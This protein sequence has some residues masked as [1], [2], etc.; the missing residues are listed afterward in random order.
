M[1][2]CFQWKIGNSNFWHGMVW[3]NDQ[4]EKK[5]EEYLAVDMCHLLIHWSTHKMTKLTWNGKLKI[6]KGNTKRGVSLS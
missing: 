4:K 3:K 1:V 6:N 5:F 2:S